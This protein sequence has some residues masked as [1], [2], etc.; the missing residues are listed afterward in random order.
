MAPSLLGIPDRVV[1]ANQVLQN[2]FMG[3]F[4]QL[5]QF[6]AHLPPAHEDSKVITLQVQPLLGTW[7][8][9]ATL[10]E[11]MRQHEVRHFFAVSLPPIKSTLWVL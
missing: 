6:E 2:N 10:N 1:R 4:R 11:S 3:M 7:K 5:A 9:F 8:S